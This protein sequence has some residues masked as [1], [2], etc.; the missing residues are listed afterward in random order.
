MVFL[1]LVCC[2]SLP[3]AAW[4]EVASDTHTGY[5]VSNQFEPAAPISFVVL[6]DQAAFDKVFGIA[7]VMRDK[8]HRL[9]PDAFVSRM[10]VAAIHRGKAVVSY[11]VERVAAE[12]KT[13]VVRYTTKSEPSDTTEFACPLIISLLKGEYDCVQFV[14][15]G[16]EIKKVATTPCLSC[17]VP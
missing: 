3:A 8:S 14:E 10:V 9:P 17:P 1:V 2:S 5:F 6:Q 15:D 11:R 4:N 12:G 13:L 7:M 16:K